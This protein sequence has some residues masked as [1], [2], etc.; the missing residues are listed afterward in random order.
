MNEGITAGIDAS[1]TVVAISFY[2]GK[3]IRDAFFVDI[4]DQE[5]NKQKAF[6]FI[7]KIENHPLMKTT[8]KINLEA[9]LGGFMR[10]KSSAK[11][12]LMLARWNGIFEYILGEKWPNIP[13]N[14]VGVNDARKK[15]FG[16]CFVKGKSGKEYTREQL[17]L[18]HPE[19]LKFEKLNKKGNWDKKNE[20]TYDSA[21]MAIY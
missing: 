20:D 2:D 4:S 6:Y 15:A 3:I 18:I 13:V 17:P 14:L 11:V 5:T 12:I 7:S 16:K 1:T 19:I 10:S 21:V 9:A 8:V